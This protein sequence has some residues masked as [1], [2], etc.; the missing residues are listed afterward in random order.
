[1][2]MVPAAALGGLGLL[3]L[4]SDGL[5]VPR[6]FGIFLLVMALFLL[7]GL[8]RQIFRSR[9]AYRDGN[10]LFF[11]KTGGPIAVPV[12]V[13]EAFFQGEGPAH[14]PGESQHQA[15]SVNLIARLSQR[16]SDWQEREVKPALGNWSEGY[17]TI[18]GTWCEPIHGDVIRRLNRRLAEVTREQQAQAEGVAGA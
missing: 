3:S 2:A 7:I 9:I 10:V 11:L 8:A 1:M 5:P 18:R 17:I 13:V 12:Q 14:L 16:E 4:W 15:K 6:F